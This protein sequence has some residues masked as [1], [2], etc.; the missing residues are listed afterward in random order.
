M[1]DPITDPLND[2]D[3]DRDIAV[4]KNDFGFTG[5]TSRQAAYVNAVSDRLLDPQRKRMF[6]LNNQFEKSRAADLA[7]ARGQLEIDQR[8]K[9]LK[10]TQES[11]LRM[12]EVMRQFNDVAD[13]EGLTPEQ[14]QVEFGRI[15]MDNAQTLSGSTFGSAYMQGLNNFLIP[16]LKRQTEDRTYQLGVDKEI[17]REQRAVER[18]QQDTF[19]ADYAASQVVDTEE[20]IL[21]IQESQP[22]TPQGDA[23][24]SL[25][26]I[27][28]DRNMSKKEM[29]L[30][31]LKE[32]R[33]K[34]ILDQQRK[35]S[36]TMADDAIESLGK[37][38]SAVLKI[39][40]D[41]DDDGTVDISPEDEAL[42]ESYRGSDLR[43]G[44]GEED[45]VSISSEAT[46]QELIKKLRQA[47]NK[48]SETKR[49]ILSPSTPSVNR[50]NL[51]SPLSPTV[52]G[53][54]RK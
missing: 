20:G 49:R 22:N 14:R 18:K 33:E 51:R 10:R 11:N 27:M 35:D 44:S 48:A 39:D 50:G 30:R 41:E 9:D 6:A 17:A 13:A 16:Q 42:L 12:G 4:S 29:Q 36:L 31:G 43:Y 5:M 52:G 3:Y 47:Q 40:S 37:A 53:G 25:A 8:K 23:I 24:R 15:Q 45:V 32:E 21:R 1:T 34:D 28:G 26:R 46:T 2:L 38:I 54:F 19:A 7:F